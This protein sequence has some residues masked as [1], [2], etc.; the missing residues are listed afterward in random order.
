MG[1]D[2]LQRLEKA[3]AEIDVRWTDERQ[4]AGARRLKRAARRRVTARRAGAALALCGVACAALWFSF[5]SSP[6]T[7]SPPAGR[8]PGA[9]LQLSDGSTATALEP[10]TELRALVDRPDAVSVELRR[11]R[12]RFEVSPRTSR[13]FRVEAGPLALEV[14][15]TAFDVE[16]APR[17][18]RV[19]VTRGAVRMFCR[20]S[21]LN[22]VAGQSE[23]C[24]DEPPAPKL[25][26]PAPRSP[27]PAADWR[28]LAQ[29]GDFDRAFN[30]L[31][32]AGSAAVRDEARELLLASDV[33]RL[34]GHPEQALAPL[35]RVLE[36]HPG[37]PRAPLAAFTLGRILLDELGRPRQAADA[38]AQAQLLDPGGPLSEDAL[39][40][41]VEAWSRAGDGP[42]ARAAAL[43]YLDRHPDGQRV[44]TVRRHGGLE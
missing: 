20:A 38:F 30:A 15:G 31:E 26:Q 25:T 9:V 8:A 18:A 17:H 7:L 28:S 37:D 3:R 39:A 23:S 41:E 5:A 19:W 29:E 11:G 10:G 14:L 40:R 2:L 36:S 4:R 35:R 1:D 13:T 42:R 32:R 24:A 34:S 27:R 12:A 33:A 16:R 21:A 44:R 22:L 43:R 6:R